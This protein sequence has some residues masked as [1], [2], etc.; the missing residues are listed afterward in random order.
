ML[1]E[2]FT[3]GEK[4]DPDQFANENYFGKRFAKQRKQKQGKKSLKQTIRLFRIEFMV[5]RLKVPTY[6]A[7]NTT[8]HKTNRV[9]KKYVYVL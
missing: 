2:L 7:N 3:Y 6:K 4:I 5:Y 9:K 8:E 1:I